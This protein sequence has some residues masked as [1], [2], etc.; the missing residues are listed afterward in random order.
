[1]LKPARPVAPP[2]ALRSNPETFSANAEMSIQYQWT[3]LPDWLEE[4]ADFTEAQADAAL[5][6]ALGG[7]LPSLSG[8]AG[9]FLRVN[10]G[11]TG[12]EFAKALTISPASDA[13]ELALT[14]AGRAM[15]AAADAAAQRGLLAAAPLASPALTGTPTAPTPT[16]GDSSTKLA[17]TEFVALAAALRAW[18]LFNGTGTVAILAS[19]NVS[20]IT[21]E[22]TGRYTINFTAAM[23]DTA[24]AVLA[25]GAWIS[26]AFHQTAGELPSGRATSSCL[27]GTGYGG[28]PG[29]TS[30]DFADAERVSVAILR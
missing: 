23:P 1:M 20:S 8:H 29:G 24:Y 6:V 16:A 25:S 19:K 17:T 2:Q 22:G 27:I 21:D 5:A 3:F 30:G 9:K 11:G 14:T 4:M 18:V 7:D 15:L 12:G 10:A 13:S 28:K 26:G